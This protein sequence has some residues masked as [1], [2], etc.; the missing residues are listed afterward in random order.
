LYAVKSS[1]MCKGDNG[2]WQVNYSGIIGGLAAG[3]IANLYY[4]AK[5]RNGVGLT[6]ENALI[7][8][9]ATAA[10]NVLQEFVVRKLTPHVS[11]SDPGN[12][13]NG[14]KSFGPIGKVLSAFVHDGD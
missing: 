10:A 2:R 1:V 4:P 12:G 7:G 13:G 9:G 5:D 14:A 11:Q 6:F 8:I 3:G